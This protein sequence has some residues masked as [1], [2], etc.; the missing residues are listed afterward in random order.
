MR[1]KRILSSLCSK[2]ILT[3]LI[4]M[5]VDEP[6]SELDESLRF[7]LPHVAAEV[8]SCEV[9]AINEAISSDE[10]LLARLYSFME[11]DAATAPSTSEAS[12]QQSSS[13]QLNPLLASFFSKAFGVLITRK[14]EQVR[15]LKI[16]A[17]LGWKSE[18]VFFYHGC[19]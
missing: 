18:T 17:F 19:L 13:Q 3:E 1:L 10:D 7:K 8:L 11:R 12:I 15:F 9:A 2:D 16:R 6:S 4:S 14:S 5:I